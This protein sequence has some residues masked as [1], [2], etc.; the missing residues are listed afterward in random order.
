[1]KTN[2]K[3][4]MLLLAFVWVN[5]VSAQNFFFEEQAVPS[6]WVATQGTLS[7]S[8]EHYKEGSRSLKWDATSSSIINI[9]FPQF[10]ASTSNAAFFQIYNPIVSNDT[11]VV[12]FLNN[13]NVRR[14]ANVLLNFRGW[15]DF[16]RAY[17][18]YAS[19]TSFT[20]D[21]KSVV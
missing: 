11:L 7:T 3:Y 18:E 17:T 19:N 12:E 13:N 10:T 1:M 15:R 2:M 14:R 16:E 4:I 5:A 21:R 6:S 9:S 20:V 8:N